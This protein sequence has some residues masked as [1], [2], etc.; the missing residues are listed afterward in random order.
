[1]PVFHVPCM[2]A[3]GKARAAVALERL[4]ECVDAMRTR[5]VWGEDFERVE[6]E[7]HER[8]VAAE[9]EVLGQLLERLDVDV[10]SVVIGGCR[11]H[12]V[13]HSTETYTTTVGT[14]RVK[15]T[16]Y[17]CARERA[18]APMELRAGIVEGHWTPLA[19]RQASRVVA[20]MTPSEGEA[21]LR[22]LGNMAPSKSS[23]DRLP[24]GLSARWEAHREAFESTLREAMVVPDEAVTVAVSL[25]GVMVPMKDGQR[26]EKR[27]RSQAR[28]RR[29]KG[30]AGYQEAGCATLSFYDAQGERL[31]TLSVARMPQP[32]KATLK[33]MLSSE[34][35]TVLG[36]RPDLHVVT[37][38][39]GAHD[40]WRYL[41]ALA[42][43]ATAVVDFYHAAEQ[44]KSALDA[45]YG[46]ND[47]KGRAQF[48]K[49]RHILLDDP[50]GVEKV[51]RA[52]AYQRKRFPR[53]KRIG[54]VLRYFRRHRHR[55]RYADT[56]A[57]S[58]PIG[59]GVVEAACKTLVTQRLKRSGMRWRHV[60]GQAI[61]TLRALLQS[62]RFERAWALLSETYRH[63]IIVPDNVVA[64][65]PTLAA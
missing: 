58:L 29:V 34:L 3:T 57:R 52:L 33:T 53:R 44:L 32:K 55:M 38:A 46:E 26:A 9:R 59:S 49:L 24:K 20:Q 1:M 39:D 7:V 63:E 62:A 56:K 30:P 5:C 14:V 65:P 25:D 64:F 18:V 45:C 16:L 50:Q 28:G 40:N 17:R 27:E 54:E 23:L 21:L 31:D 47:A 35:D 37:V 4:T 15:R 13:L 11:H 12:R 43:E 36:R 48:H 41:D 6:R 22:E 10:A 61:L 2:S 60:G 51:I 8:F 42:P 19:A